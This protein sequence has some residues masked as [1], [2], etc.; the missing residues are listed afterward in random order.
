[1]TDIRME[2]EKLHAQGLVIRT[3]EEYGAVQDYRS[4]RDCDIP[5]VAFFLHIAVVD[6][7][8]DLLGTEDQVART[9][10]RIGQTRFGSGWS[11]NAGAFNTG[12]LYEGQPLTRRGTH[13]VNTFN[14]RICPHHGGSLVA[15]VTSSGMN[16]NVNARAMVL[17]QQ[18]GD[19]VT[20]V[21]IDSAARWAAAQIRS[22]LARP[23]ARW[24]GHR[25]V[26]AKACPGDRAFARIPDLQQ[27]TNHYVSTGLE[28]DDMAWDEELPKINVPDDKPGDHLPA[29]QTLAQARGFA[30]AAYA[31]ARRAELAVKA[32]AKGLG[33]EVEAAVAA[34]LE[35]AVIDVNV[36]IGTNQE[37]QA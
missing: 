37:E 23:D 12:R 20:D 10:E 7:P 31:S 30:A 32:L 2:R 35:D 21:Q 19:P 5:A 36:N 33:P 17:P 13:T 28:E 29:G 11:Y 4:D 16:N 27:L 18:V 1:M 6:D 8:S 24:H 26:T 15:P 25:C 14:R 9:I 3:R 34:A 22:G